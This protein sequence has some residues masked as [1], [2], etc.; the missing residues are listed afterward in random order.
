MSTYTFSDIE[1]PSSRSNVWRIFGLW[2]LGLAIILLVLLAWFMSIARAAL[3]EL[4]GSVSVPGLSA[5]V[6]VTRNSQGVP[7][8]EAANLDDLFFAQGYVTAQDRLFQMDL[9]R[10]AA[11]GELSEVVGEVA[12][13]HDRQQRI[14]GIRAAAEKGLAAITPED[15]QQ[16]NAYAQGVNAFIKWHGE[17]LP[18]EFRLLH[19]TPRPWNVQDSL[20]IAYQ[21][22][23][24]LSTSP[25]DALTRE[26]I[27]AKLGPELTSDLYVNTSWRD[28]PPGAD[29]PTPEPLPPVSDKSSR[30]AVIFASP[31]RITELLWQPWLEPFFR[32]GNF[33]IGS[34]NWVV[35]GAHTVTG[36]P[37]LSNDMHLGHQMPNLWYEAHLR[38]GSFDVAGVTL[39]GYPYVIVGHN[40]RVA[41]G[42]T[43]V[44]PTVEDVYVEKFNE[45]GQY[46]TTQGWKQPDTR[47]EVI[48]I[49]GK[50]DVALDVQSTR[51]GPIVTELEPGESR[52]IALRW[53]LYEGI[54]SPFFKIDSAQTW[55]EFRHAFSELDAP[56]QNVVY[57]DVDGNIGYQTTG[58]IPIRASGD[59][60]LPVDGSDNAHEWTGY[61][62][63][64]KLPSV[65]NP[66]S[67]VIGTA[68]SRITP[69]GYP[70]SVSIEWE[71][72]WRTDRIYRVLESGK[73]FSRADMLSLETDTSSELDRFMADKIVDAIDHAGN[74]SPQARKAANI[75][76]QWNGQMSAESAAPTIASETRDELKRLLLESKLGTAN[77]D[78]QLSW[79][80]YKWMQETVWL[81]NVLTTQPARWL[82]Q[83]FSNYN[84]L[85]LAATEHALK[86]APQELGSWRWGSQNSLTIQN[87]ILG[88][89]PILRRWSGTGT[90][91][92]SGSVYTV[93][94]VGHAHGPSERFTADISDW[95]M[96]TLNTVTGQSGNFL[97]PYY[98][99]QWQAWY[100]GYTFAL[101]FSRTA[102]VNSAA[103]RLLLEPK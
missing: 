44:G 24:T 36:K 11:A 31:H 29:P 87:P 70:Y 76:R 86:K 17:R 6:S 15:R 98:M 58:K 50:P 38:S 42:F 14:L 68:N 34:N 48:K 1:S 89:V 77:D 49:K 40:Q 79:K 96:S 100:T 35:S 28:H 41:W 5:P 30:T 4:D 3:P 63:F 39:P 43:N 46:L 83:N 22:V 92:Q 19:Y 57:A 2:A 61:I 94:A 72:P 53:T 16:F 59:G 9:M 78:S 12:L 23:Q 54:R 97:S 47:H 33:P 65:F 64:D 45:L 32:N 103:H 66:S 20:M 69:D 52:K 90:N 81:E 21:M 25:R 62:P 60:S 67:G 71:A 95:D 85:I 18:L 56:A 75:L 93:K 80:S 99:D 91:P 55:Q 74:P 10:R 102:V 8:I 51:H 26:R 7:T 13:K 84:E 73:K 101:Q 27:L 88:Q 82:P 37:L